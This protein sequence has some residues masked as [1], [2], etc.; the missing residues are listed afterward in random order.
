MDYGDADADGYTDV[1]VNVMDGDG[2]EDRVPSSGD[3]HVLSGFE[4]ALL[5]GRVTAPPTSTPTTTPTATATPTLPL[6]GCPGD[7]DGDGR[8]TV[9]ELVRSV[10]DLLDEPVELRC[11]AA[12]LDGDGAVAVDEIVTA[13][14]ANLEGCTS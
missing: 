13:V 4:L 10:R 9:A 6:E 14:R 12:D 3:A 1:M 8:V 11:G 2:F 7:C 5:A